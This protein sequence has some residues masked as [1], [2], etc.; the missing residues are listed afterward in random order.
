MDPKSSEG[1]TNRGASASATGTGNNWKME[2][3]KYLRSLERK[4]RAASERFKSQI[5]SRSQDMT[6]GERNMAEYIRK[7]YELN[8]TPIIVNAPGALLREIYT[9][10]KQVYSIA[11]EC[12]GCRTYG[13]GEKCNNLRGKPSKV[14]GTEIDVY[15]VPPNEYNIFCKEDT[16]PENKSDPRAHAKWLAKYGY[17]N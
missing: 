11:C 10:G 13:F 14:P 15:P 4:E 1:E 3:K 12:N 7:H 2:H 8:V 6:T 9:D 17:F 16:P 5:T